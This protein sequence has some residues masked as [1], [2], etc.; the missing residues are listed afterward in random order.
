ASWRHAE[1]LPALFNGMPMGTRIL[2]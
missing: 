1:Q 2:A